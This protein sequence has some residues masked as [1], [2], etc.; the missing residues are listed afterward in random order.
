FVWNGLR[1]RAS[2]VDD[3]VTLTSTWAQ[4]DSLFAPTDGFAWGQVPTDWQGGHPRGLQLNTDENFTVVYDGD[5]L[6]PAGDS[7]IFLHADDCAFLEYATDGQTYAPALHSNNSDVLSPML[8]FD[9]DTWV[10]IHAAF[11]EDNGQARF[12]LQIAQGGTQTTVDATRLRAR[13]STQQ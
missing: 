2:R 11:G 6:M 4:L 1:A 13:V 5:L 9:A 3:F 7:P 10:P 12:T 8:H